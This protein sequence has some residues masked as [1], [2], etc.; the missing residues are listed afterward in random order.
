M[1]LA[2]AFLWAAYYPFVLGVHPS[3][4][5]SGLLTLPFLIG[6]GA[7]TLMALARGEGAELRRLWGD[8]AAW[9]RAALLVTMQVSVL[10]AT[11]L[12]GAVDTSLLA[13]LG[14]VVLTPLFLVLLFSE[15]SERIRTLGFLG[16]IAVCTGGR[17]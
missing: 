10:A 13:L 5:P 6:G 14:D 11:Y 3:T 4:S 1:S 9:G 2:A 15:G 12:T 7:F 8:P 17:P 16:G